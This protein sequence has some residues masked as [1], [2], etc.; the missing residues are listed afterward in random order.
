MYCL[1]QT[2]QKTEVAF[3]AT[4]AVVGALLLGTSLSWSQ[5]TG[6]GVIALTVTAMGV[7]EARA[8]ARDRAESVPGR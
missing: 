8:S 7:R 6:L 3:P 5:W 4:A 1:T 2:T